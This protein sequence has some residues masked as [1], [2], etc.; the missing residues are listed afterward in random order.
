MFGHSEA[1]VILL[2]APK[3][4]CVPWPPARWTAF[5]SLQMF[6]SSNFYSCRLHTSHIWKCQISLSSSEIRT[7][8]NW[9]E[10]LTKCNCVLPVFLLASRLWEDCFLFSHL[11]F[12]KQSA[13]VSSSNSNSSSWIPVLVP[14]DVVTPVAVYSWILVL[15]STFRDYITKDVK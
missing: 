12:Y 14:F 9:R 13:V 7:L 11:C 8:S 2:R 15:L 6:S 10:M 1:S 4:H 3:G 5:F